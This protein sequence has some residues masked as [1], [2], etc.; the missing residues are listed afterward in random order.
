MFVENNR[1]PD[2]Y[3]HIKI[4]ILVKNVIKN[5]CWILIYYTTINILAIKYYI[6]IV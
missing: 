3:H 2:C 5:T 4:A 1:K 6:N